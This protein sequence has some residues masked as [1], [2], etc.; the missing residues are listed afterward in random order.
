MYVETGSWQFALGLYHIV[1]AFSAVR[2]LTGF[3][4]VAMVCVALLAMAYARALRVVRAAL[5][6]CDSPGG[7]ATFS[8]SIDGLLV[9]NVVVPL[10]APFLDRLTPILASRER[11]ETEQ[12]A[13]K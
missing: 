5:S 13:D 11:L 12:A 4:V 3:S 8:D 6:D 9:T 2:L 1:S 10:A 7:A